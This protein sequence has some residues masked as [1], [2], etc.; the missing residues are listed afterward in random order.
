VEALRGGPRTLVP[1]EPDVPPWLD[2][3]VPEAAVVD[4]ERPIGA[5]EL[6][7]MVAPL[8]TE[9][10]RRWPAVAAIALVLALVAAWLWT[11][12]RGWF[13][14]DALVE[15]FQPLVRSPYAAPLVLAVFLVGGMVLVP[16][17][18][19]IVA[20]AAAFGPVLGAVYA[21]S[22]SVLSAAAGY[23]I[24]SALGPDRVRRVFGSR[25]GKLGGRLSKHGVL[26]MTAVRLVPLAPFGVVNLAAGA[27]R[28]RRRDFLLGT[29]F[30]MLPGVIGA[31]LFAD[32][33]LRTVQ[34]P[35]AWNV[36]VLA[37]VVLALVV[38]GR[39]LERRFAARGGSGEPG[40][41]L[42]TSGRTAGRRDP[43]PRR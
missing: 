36:A 39:W 43:S 24:G 18:L 12:M 42:R 31:A 30:G 16:V 11:P 4:P 15:L 17:T 27:A 13:D 10:P 3:V 8:E 20:T 25:L 33:L 7:E 23:A 9:R 41:D 22:G 37:L 2:S 14:P 34:Q 26:V 35:G 40:A 32:Q 5:G 19:L 38:A 1:L 21:L 29:T 6:R 28:V